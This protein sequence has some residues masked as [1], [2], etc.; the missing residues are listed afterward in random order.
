VN[1]VQLC[2]VDQ[3]TRLYR[4][5][6]PSTSFSTPPRAC[7][8][9]VAATRFTR[10]PADCLRPD[11][12]RA[13]PDFRPDEERR[14]ALLLRAPPDFRDDD[15][16]AD[17]LRPDFRPDLRLAFRDDFRPPFR[18]D[19]PAPFRAPAF[20]RE[21][22]RLERPALRELLREDFFLDAMNSLLV[23]WWCDGAKQDSRALQ[24]T[25]RVHLA[26]DQRT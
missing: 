18:P 21:P 13:P 26:H 16:R 4:S 2:A 15:L 1:S 17:A 10:A 7:S 20:F 9:T 25:T 23:R 3:V 6:A 22:P 5:P 14:F 8:T 12:R 24:A 11:F 19:L